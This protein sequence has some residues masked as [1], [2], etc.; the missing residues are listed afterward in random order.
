M[1][2]SAIVIG[3]VI[4]ALFSK[5]MDVGWDA[6]RHDVNVGSLVYNKDN[7][8]TKLTGIFRRLRKNEKFDRLETRNEQLARF[9]TLYVNEPGKMALGNRIR[10][11][12]AVESWYVA[13]LAEHTD[14]LQLS[15]SEGLEYD[16]DET[17]G[18]PGYQSI[19]RQYREL[20]DP[21][22]ASPY[23]GT[24]VRVSDWDGDKRFTLSRSY[25]WDQYVTNQ[26]E[27]VDEPLER[28]VAGSQSHMPPRL[29]KSSLRELNMRDG[30]LL[31][32]RDSPLANTIGIASTIVTSDGYLVLPKRNQQ[33]HYQSG[34]EGCSTSGVLEW[35]GGLTS[36]FM[37]ELIQQMKSKEGPQEL[38]LDPKRSVAHPLAFAREF[39]RAGKPQFFFH[40]W[41]D[42]RLS[43]FETRWRGSRYP[44]EEYD[45][46]RWIELYEPDT[47]RDPERA[48]DQATER[49]VAMLSMNSAISLR[50]GHL[51]VLSEEARANLFCLAVYLK[52]HGP[53]AFPRHWI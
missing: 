8:F 50:D 25:Y 20:K 15:A 53:A 44:Q 28:I 4:E 34:Y 52:A 41:T 29:L 48:I 35:T 18:I 12:Y 6:L 38:L 37:N 9:Y 21:G 43:E 31:S 1:E 33:V 42:Q 45:S 11:G 5:A 7:T 27:I 16:V 51:V 26:K 46:I 14:P 36:D 47:L 32:F 13:A 2:P 24:T 17:L 39:E 40:I 30:R 3:A 19:A 49:L 23:K 10:V 22:K